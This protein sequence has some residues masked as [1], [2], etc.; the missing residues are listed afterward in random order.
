MTEKEGILHWKIF[1]ISNQ[2]V[3]FMIYL[4]I[5]LGMCS[6][7]TSRAMWAEGERMVSNKVQ[8]VVLAAGQSTRFKTGR[9]KL[10]ERICGQEMILYSTRLLE[11]LDIPT[12]VVVGYQKDSVI[13]VIQKRHN[14]FVSFVVQQEQRGTGHA[15][16]CTMQI[17]ERDFILIMNGDMPLV[18][19]DIIEKLYEQHVTTNAQVSFV[20]SH[21]E[22]TQ[23]AYGRVI[24]DE[25]GIKIVEAKHFTGDPHEHCW[26]NAGVYLISR[27]FLQEQIARIEQNEKTKEFYLTDLIEMASV[28]GLGVCTVIAPYDRIRGINN[29]QEL[30]A[31]EQ[32]KRSE[33]IKYWMDNGVHFSVAQSVHIDLDVRI[34][35]GS[36]IGCG[37]HL[38]GNT[39]MGKNSKINE[40]SSLENV[41]MGDSSEVLQHC[42]LADCTLGNN[43]KV[44]PF[45]HIRDH[46]VI[47]DNSIIGNF[48]EVARTTIGNCT[49]AKHLSYLG[50]AEIG[51]NVN[52]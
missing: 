41:I 36:Y 14:D 6:A 40:N 47:L 44:G 16:Q 13:E 8:A 27:T 51:N 34:G 21:C 25:N 29:F 18:T 1:F 22:D 2:I 17:W 7:I 4:L 48:V 20:I 12:T 49:K 50:D 35:A 32:V 24:K 45:A 42:V 30:W 46:S 10:L 23:S 52:I 9:T 37:V 11:A 3:L 26:I 38:L 33:L 15:V 43:V 28:Q 19:A 31:A 39:K 5:T